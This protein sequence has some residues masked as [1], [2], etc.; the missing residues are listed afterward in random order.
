PIDVPTTRTPRETRNCRAATW[1]LVHATQRPLSSTPTRTNAMR[2]P[3]A[4]PRVAP[5]IVPATWLPWCLQS[6]VTCS[7]APGVESIPLVELPAH[8]TRPANS[9]CDG[10]NPVSITPTVTPSPVTPCAHAPATRSESSPQEG[11]KIGRA[12]CR[13]SE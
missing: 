13:E 5:A 12:S 2:A 10:S 6:E 1:A 3:G 8:A 11:S 7:D 9:G 4:T